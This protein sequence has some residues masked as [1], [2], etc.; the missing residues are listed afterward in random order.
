MSSFVITALG[1]LP[2][3]PK[4]PFFTVAAT[5][6]VLSG[7]VAL[8]G[9]EDSREALAGAERPLLVAGPWDGGPEDRAAVA[10]LARAMAMSR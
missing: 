6:Y 2:G 1:L 5:L 4:I 7:R 8:P 9:D 10:R 3:L